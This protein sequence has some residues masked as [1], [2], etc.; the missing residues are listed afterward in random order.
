[1][2][3]FERQAVFG[4]IHRTCLSALLTDGAMEA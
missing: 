4:S 2:T 3:E 1:V